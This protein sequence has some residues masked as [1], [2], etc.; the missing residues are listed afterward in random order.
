MVAIISTLHSL[1][2]VHKDNL[3]FYDTNLNICRLDLTKGEDAKE[4][5]VSENTATGLVSWYA[6]EILTLG[7]KDYLFYCDSS[8]YGNSY[9]KYVDLAGKVVAEDTD[10]DGEDDLF[11]LEDHTF[12]GKVLDDDKAS[13]MQ[14]KIDDLVEDLD[15]NS[16]L[17]FDKDEDGKYILD[18]NG[19]LT[20]SKVEKVKAEYDKL[21]GAIKEKVDAHLFDDYARA[22]EIASLMYKLEGVNKLSA[23]DKESEEFKSFKAIYESVKAEINE[24][25]KSG[26]YKTL[27]SLIENNIKANFT[28][29]TALFEAKK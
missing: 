18:A 3:Y 20:L 15:E 12:L 2:T 21:D 9:I 16:A 14:A 5:R 17:V 25:Y 11:R 4:E 1:Y 23:D 19:K 29:A 13:I 6:P 26:E 10:D 7:G 27:G 28:K 24:Y 8:E 22:T